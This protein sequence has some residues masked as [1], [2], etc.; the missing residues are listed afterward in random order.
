MFHHLASCLS[1]MS[2]DIS[3]NVTTLIV[4]MYLYLYLGRPCCSLTSIKMQIRRSSFI[5]LFIHSFIHS[6][7]TSFSSGTTQKRSQ[8]QRGWI[9]LSLVVAE[10]THYRK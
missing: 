4:Y 2:D 5:H 9:L 1:R 7:G 8:P 3:L 10:G 6:L